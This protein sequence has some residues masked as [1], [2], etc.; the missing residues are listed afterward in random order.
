[1]A[2]LVYEHRVGSAPERGIQNHNFRLRPVHHVEHRRRSIS[3]GRYHH[4]AV[5]EHLGDQVTRSR[6]TFTHDGVTIA[7]S[8]RSVSWRFWCC[9]E[10]S[11]GHI[12]PAYNRYRRFEQHEFRGVGSRRPGV[13]ISIAGLGG[14]ADLSAMF[15]DGLPEPE[16]VLGQWIFGLAILLSGG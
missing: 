14:G 4:I 9:A 11:S 15:E 2:Q 16:W 5:F 8:A 10:Y 6:V 3:L 12:R 13:L 7:R 1:M